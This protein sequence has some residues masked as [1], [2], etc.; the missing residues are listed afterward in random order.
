MNEC[1]KNEN[2]KTRLNLYDFI[3]YSKKFVFYTCQLNKQKMWKNSVEAMGIKMKSEQTSEKKNNK[4]DPSLP[5]KQ[6]Q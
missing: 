6:Y 2:F 4:H 1:L 5:V 3:H